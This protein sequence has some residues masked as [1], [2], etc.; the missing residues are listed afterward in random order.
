MHLIETPPSSAFGK[1][2]EDCDKLD[3]YKIKGKTV[4][5]FHMKVGSE[6]VLH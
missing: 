3:F 5:Y 2:F 6:D 1:E 4:T